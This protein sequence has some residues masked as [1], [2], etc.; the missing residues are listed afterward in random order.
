MKM[1]IT[2]FAKNN[3]VKIPKEVGKISGN[4]FVE[5]T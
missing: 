3:F 2:H 4:N 5:K 1:G